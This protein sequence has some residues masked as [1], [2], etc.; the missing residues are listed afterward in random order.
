MKIYSKK[1]N[2]SSQT[3]FYRLMYM[4]KRY[5]CSY[6]LNDRIICKEFIQRILNDKSIINHE[7]R[8]ILHNVVNLNEFYVSDV[9]VA[10]NDICALK[11]DT[12]KQEILDL[13]INK[14]YTRIPVYQN[15]LD[16]IIGFIHLKDILVQ[17]YRDTL[18]IHEII[19]EIIFVPHSMHVMDLLIK[20]KTLKVHIAVAVDEYSCTYGLVTM[21]N[22]IE[23]IIGDISDE[24]DIETT[25]QLR[26]LD[27]N[28]FEVDAH[29]HIL[30]IEEKL[31]ITLRSEEIKD[32]YDTIS[33]LIFNITGYVPEVGEIITSTNGITFKVK[34]ADSKTI[35][36]VIIDISKYN[37]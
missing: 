28:K 5:L 18:N 33:G 16:N 1:L 27:E 31:G 34:K 14:Q 37:A 21:V 4:I 17:L 15:N 11:V 22:I 8:R 36:R 3:F 13:L 10:R 12:T 20:M 35:Y 19:R 23:R 6:L 9:I 7:E 24:H 32:N 29:E 2:N 25:F 26:K 30:V